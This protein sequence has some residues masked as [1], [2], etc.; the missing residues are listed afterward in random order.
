MRKAV[1]ILGL[2]VF[3]VSSAQ[4]GG[5]DFL[6][7]LKARVATALGAEF[8]A[9]EDLTG[10]RIAARPLALP[11]GEKWVDVERYNVVIRNGARIN[12]VAHVRV[13]ERAVATLGPGG[14]AVDNRLTQVH[15]ETV[16]VMLFYYRGPEFL[17]ICWGKVR[18]S[19]GWHQAAPLT[20]E[21]GSILRPDG[22]TYQSWGQDPTFA[23]PE[24]DLREETVH[25]PRKWWGGTNG[26]QMGNVSEFTVRVSVNG[27]AV[28]VLQ[29]LGGFA[30]REYRVL[31]GYGAVRSLQIDYLQRIEGTDRYLLGKSIP[32]YPFSL[33][34]EGVESLQLV[35]A[36]PS[37]GVIIQ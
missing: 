26:I 9:V 1:V 17:G 36:P 32:D 27:R 35:F 22:W 7:F 18:F 13:Y 25:L 4:A 33:Y 2:L 16:P 14:K 34:S 12:A 3:I 8:P 6:K 5:K 11:L 24:A 30:Y 29:P 20:C 10:V 23:L 21:V 31:A 19:P 37:Q 15:Q 28:A